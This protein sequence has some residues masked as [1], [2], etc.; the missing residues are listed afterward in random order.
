MDQLLHSMTLLS[1]AS[2]TG[3]SLA[4]QRSGRYC[5]SVAGTFGGA[6]VGLQMLGPD[7]ATWIGI[8][9]DSGALAIT[10]ARA[11][12]VLLPAGQFRASVVGGSGAS[13]YARLDRMVD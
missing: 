12:A 8:E 9:D 5:F 2:A 1:A 4:C 3:S 13:L 10:S 7:G 11:V 6:T